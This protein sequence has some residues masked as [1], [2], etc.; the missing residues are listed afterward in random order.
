MRGKMN[1]AARPSALIILSLCVLSCILRC[2]ASGERI[3]VIENRDT[4]DKASQPSATVEH[5]G[6]L[7]RTRYRWTDASTEYGPAV[8]GNWI[9]FD[10][11]RNKFFVSDPG[12]NRIFVLEA[13]NESLKG[14]KTVPGAFGIDE[15]PNH[16]LLY[17]GTTVGDVYAIDPSTMQVVR[18]YM[19]ESIGPNG[20]HAYA[21]RALSDGRL[22]LLGFRGSTQT[23]GAPTG[24]AG[25]SNFSSVAIWEPASNAIKIYDGTIFAFT[26]TGDRSQIAL[27]ANLNG[28]RNG[29]LFT[30]DAVTGKVNLAPLDGGSI[31][32]A[33]P[34]G[35]S[36]L[37]PVNQGVAVY[38]AH[39]LRKTSVIAMQSGVG[40]MAVGPDSKTLYVS[41][42]DIVFAYDI[43]TGQQTGWLPNLVV[44]PV[45]ARGT[46]DPF[47]QAFDNTWLL[48][49][50][51]EQGVG[52]LDT[53]AFRTGPVGSAFTNAYLD[54]ATG[55][56]EGGTYTEW[57]NLTQPA[58]KLSSVLFG[59]NAA[60]SV[61]KI[62]GEFHARSPAGAPGPADVY[63]FVTDGGAQVIPQGFSYGPSIVS[64]TPDVATANGGGD[65]L[66]YGYGFGRISY[67]SPIPGDLRVEVNRK[68]V[69]ITG[70]NPLVYGGSAPFPLQSLTYRIPP[71]ANGES[72][73][74]TVSTREGI[75]TASKAIRYV[76]GIE[77]YDLPGAS[78]AQGVYDLQRDLYY[79]TDAA[80]IRVFSRA[81][82]TWLS[83]IGV[84]A[85]PAGK[86]HRLWGISL[87][88]DASKLVVSDAGT[89]MIYLIDPASSET[90][91]VFPV[92]TYFD[93]T[94][95]ENQPSIPSGVSVTNDGFVY[96]ASYQPDSSESDG[97][98]RLDTKTGT[99]TDYQVSTEGAGQYRIVA[100]KDGAHAYFSEGSYL[101]SVNTATGDLFQASIDQG[102]CFES[103]ELALSPDQ[104]S[105]VTSAY[106]YDTSHN[107][108]SILSLNDR[109]ALKVTYVLGA[110]FSPNGGLLF[111]PS[112]NGIDVFDGRLG[113]LLERI[114]L[115]VEL[116]TNYD[117][118]VADG[119]DH[120][121]VALTGIA[122]SGIAIIDLNGISVPTALPYLDPVLDPDAPAAFGTTP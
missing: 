7:L 19:G 53:A 49:G 98:L 1:T 75:A 92:V 59:P 85:A 41:S 6:S 42:G 114:G 4:S 66:I 69:V 72:V 50:P 102:C 27:I 39:T 89:S 106:L 101:F 8:Y 90:Q 55:P 110:K 29:G 82:K 84:P 93:G 32:A 26:L 116:S 63:A 73:D 37:V 56:A 112:T 62:P 113:T 118:L 20:F 86:S 81:K 11:V 18:R 99:I 88:P 100:S 52:F 67:E 103:L 58:P 117:A 5:F 40:T 74:L 61:S 3:S 34:D 22:A 65:G 9:V 51:M 104:S 111:V 122:G 96:Y 25:I 120:V 107:P 31:L 44:E 80:E 45:S 36:I 48:A 121:L 108:T 76:P 105:L 30:V 95:Q 12:G 38:D 87:S 64:V 78:L 10:P 24:T 2:A 57:E 115:P 35:K 43:G 119:Q 46:S 54:P 109:D 15:T 83:S 60:K 79:F 33:T 71:G 21:V 17:A 97:F 16:S 23:S 47:L 13:A 68:P 14:S 91:A 94:A 77:K 28:Y 70:F